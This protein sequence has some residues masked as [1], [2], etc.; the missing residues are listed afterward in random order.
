VQSELI[1]GEPRVYWV[2]DAKRARVLSNR[3]NTRASE[4]TND[5]RTAQRWCDALNREGAPA[6]QPN[7]G[8]QDE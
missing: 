8:T 5:K 1:R 7:K 2:E 3:I 6:E 4:Y